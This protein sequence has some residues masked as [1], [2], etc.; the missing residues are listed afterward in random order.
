LQFL[1]SAERGASRSYLGKLLLGDEFIL[2]KIDMAKYSSVHFAVI[3]IIKM[4]EECDC[5]MPKVQ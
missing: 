3:L 2:T 4:N 5:G 1:L